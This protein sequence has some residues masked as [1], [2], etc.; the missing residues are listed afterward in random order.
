MEK[1]IYYMRLAIA[2]AKEGIDNNEYPFGCCIV[3][4]DEEYVVA[5]N[6]CFTDSNPLMHAE[7]RAMN[8]MFDELK[9]TSLQ[10]TTIYT[11]TIP[12]LM[13]IGAISW[14]KIPRL[15]YGL[16]INDSINCDFEEINY[17]I[18]SIINIFPYKIEVVKSELTNECLDLYNQWNKKNRILRWFKG[19]LKD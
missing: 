16:S 5:C 2:S 13:C 19:K 17:D 3:T 8:K 7:I 14:A 4:D 15:V 18:N 10:N 6:S 1:D 11:T 12:C 9:V